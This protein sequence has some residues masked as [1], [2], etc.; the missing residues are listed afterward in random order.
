MD[1]YDYLKLDHEHVKQLFKQFEKSELLIRKKQIAFLISQELMVHAHS[2]Q[3]TFYRALKQF[4]TTKDDAS[5][6]QKEHKEIEEQISLV[7]HSKDFGESWI[8]K[9]EKLKEIVEHHVKDEEGPMFKQAQ[10]VLSKEDAFILKEQ[11]H[12]LKQHLLL[13]LQKEESATSINKEKSLTKNSYKKNAPLKKTPLKKHEAQ[14]NR[15]H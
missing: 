9:V 5:H 2:E 15:L 10:T 4:E 3:E 13:A 8:K 1:I 7:L 14:S 6:G 11:M 12:Y